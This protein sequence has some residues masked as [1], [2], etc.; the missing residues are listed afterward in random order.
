MHLIIHVEL[1]Q[2]HNRATSYIAG[3]CIVLPDQ[4]WTQTNSIRATEIFLDAVTF[5]KV[6][7]EG[8]I[9]ES[10]FYTSMAQV[11]LLLDFFSHFPMMF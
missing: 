6:P 5:V 1:Q 8:C 11:A 3:V 10:C 9:Q 7:V 4:W 2:C